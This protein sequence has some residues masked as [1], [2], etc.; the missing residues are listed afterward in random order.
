MQP[1]VR[2]LCRETGKPRPIRLL[3]TC[4]GC[5]ADGP[6]AADAPGMAMSTISVIAAA[7]RCRGTPVPLLRALIYRCWLKLAG[8]CSSG[9]RRR[10]IRRPGQAGRSSRHLCRYP[11]PVRS[12]CCWRRYCHPPCRTGRV[13]AM[14]SRCRRSRSGPATAGPP[15]RSA[16]AP[17]SGA[18]GS[19]P[20]TACAA[21]VRQSARSRSR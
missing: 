2:R 9:L 17:A 6:G 8:R 7:H 5:R 20:R 12:W 16:P 21:P 10:P 15:G 18:P 3:D 4:E 1:Y 19:S 14:T 11:G 13:L